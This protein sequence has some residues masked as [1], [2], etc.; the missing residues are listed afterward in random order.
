M[1]STMGENFSHTGNPNNHP[2]N[3]VCMDLPF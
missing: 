1:Y 2:E 3:V